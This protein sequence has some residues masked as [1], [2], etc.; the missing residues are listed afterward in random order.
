MREEERSLQSLWR[1]R[2]ASFGREM[3][4]YVRYVGQSGLS[5]VLSFLVI[6]FAIRYFQLLRDV[7]SDFP[8]T[9]VGVLALTIAVA[10]SPLRTWLS[11][12]DIVFLMPREAEMNVYIF[13]SFRRAAVQTA[14]LLGAL[15]LLYAPIYRQGP[16]KAG[17]AAVALIAA[18]VKALSMWGAWRERQVAWPRIRL[19]L[20]SLRWLAIALIMAAALVSEPWQGA[21]FLVLVAAL[22]ALLY[23]L[24]RRHQIPW[25]RLIAEETATRSRH[26][27]FMSFFVD[28]PALPSPVT[29]RPYLSW[30]IRLVRYKHENTYVYL[31]ALTVIRTELAGI[32]LRLLVLLGLILYW[33]AESAWLGGWGAAAMYILFVAIFGF[34]L[35]ALHQAHRHTVWHHIYPLPESRRLADLVRVDRLA[36]LVCALL[37]WLPLGV[38]LLV[39]G[40]AAAAAASLIAAVCYIWIIRPASL[41]RKLRREAEDDD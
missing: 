16:G 12:A 7:P 5:L 2:A 4:P 26:Y 13:R 11:A 39:S 20:R 1:R 29:S 24:P 18:A 34:Q 27:R 22:M 14:L 35:G 28:V 3:L 6:T 41:S 23:R 30:L 37:L 19:L 40:Y 33:L 9:A 17:I 38:T 15:L 31:Y 32:M 21:L 10:W 25:E 36:L 8:V